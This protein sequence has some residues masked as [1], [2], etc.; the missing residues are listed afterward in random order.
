[1]HMDHQESPCQECTLHRQRGEDYF[2][3]RP[4]GCGGSSA[5]QRPQALQPSQDH[6]GTVQYVTTALGGISEHPSIKV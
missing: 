5:F 3:H 2:F 6:T 4:R 1:M